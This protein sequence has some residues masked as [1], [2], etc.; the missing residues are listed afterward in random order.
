MEFVFARLLRRHRPGILVFVTLLLASATATSL[1]AARVFRTGRLTYAF[2]VYNLVLAWIPLG[3]AA[4]ASVLDRWPS[5]L[6]RGLTLVCL[7][8]W[9]VF[10]PNAPYIVTDLVHLHVRDNRLIWLDLTALQAFAWT[11]LAVG[12]VSLTLVQRVVA[13]R[14]GRMMS[15][16]FASVVL[17]ASAFGIYLGRFHRWNSWDVV[18]NP[19]GLLEDVA[20]TLLHPLANA[21]VIAYCAVLGA[22]LLTAYAVVQ[23]WSGLREGP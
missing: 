14:V 16:L 15:W 22:F 6:A 5:K 21:Q 18:R 8:A 2:L 20:G 9:L 4:A 17:A 13:R 7:A 3:F 19:R 11:G 12:F 10:F 23:A 1:V